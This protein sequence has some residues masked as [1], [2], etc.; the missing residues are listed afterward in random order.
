MRRYVFTLFEAK[1]RDLCVLHVDLA[2]PIHVVEALDYLSLAPLRYRVVEC[3]HKELEGRFRGIFCPLGCAYAILLMHLLVS[4]ASS[5][6]L[7]YI[8]RCV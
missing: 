3:S 4:L 8:S 5:V 2:L 6:K 1:K 7:A